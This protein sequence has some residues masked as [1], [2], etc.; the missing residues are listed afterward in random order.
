MMKPSHALK[1]GIIVSIAVVILFVFSAAAPAMSSSQQANEFTSQANLL[2]NPTLNANI[3]WSTFNHGWKTLEYN[4]GTANASLNAGL[5]N[6]YKNPISVNPTDIIANGALQNDK[7]GDSNTI[8]ENTSA[9]TDFSTVNDSSYAKLASSNGTIRICGNTSPEKAT[10]PQFGIYVNV[11][12]FPSNNLQYDYL[13]FIYS[14]KGTNMTGVNGKIFLWNSSA[15]G[16]RFGSDIYPGQT[17][18]VTENLAEFQKQTAYGATLNTTG[19]GKTSYLLITPEILMPASP[20]TEDYTLTVYAMAF[21]S[22]A[23][24]LGTNSTGIVSKS[25]G[26][27]ELTSFSPSFTYQ[28]IINNGYT[29]AVSQPLQNLTTQQNEITGNPKYVEQVMYQGNYFLP[30]APDLSYSNSIISE[31]L[32]INASQTTVLDINGLSLLNTISG[33]NGTITLTTVNPNQKTTLIQIVDYT[34][35]QWESVSGPPGFF[36]VNGI[37]Y[38]IDEIVLGI[39]AV[40][41]L[42]GGAAVARTRSL[43]RV[44]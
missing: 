13:T 15:H 14:L 25:L 12:D 3:T 23:M 28:K 7:L 30:S 35:S 36:S 19:K 33:K 44:K 17:A 18:Y 42:A 21:S 38:Y 41:G 20:T 26:N 9:Y 11:A 43:R 27:A 8:W 2:P 29:V 40:V 6:Y 34:S 32:S 5:S 4:N 1:A 22:Y 16:A 37:L 39:I 24:N 31:N 10:N